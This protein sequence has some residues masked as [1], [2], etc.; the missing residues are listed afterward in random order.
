MK[1][2]RNTLAIVFALVVLGGPGSL[3]MLQNSGQKK[4]PTQV[5]EEATVL[6]EGQMTEKQRVHGRLFKHS[7]RKLR[8]IAGQQTGDIQVVEGPPL[9]IVTQTSQRRRPVFQSALC[10]ADAVV[11]GTI[12]EKS[13][14]FTED[15]K[16]IFTDY[17]IIVDE[18]IK[19]NARSAVLASNLITATNDG[20]A[21][22]LNNQTFRARQEGFDPPLVSKRYL[23][24]LRFIPETDSYLLYGNGIFELEGQEVLA[25]GP[26][27]RDEMAKLGPKDG[28]TFL[29]EVRSYAS[30]QCLDQ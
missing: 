2:N 3:A 23:L 13:S 6:R 5:Q 10:R 29:N 21:V 26:G 7:G 24:F 18:V 27:S 30:S 19:N 9:V 15:G 1:S 8:E 28:V 25:L 14:Q 12:N 4:G 11:L 22:V 16:F 17:Q 20:G